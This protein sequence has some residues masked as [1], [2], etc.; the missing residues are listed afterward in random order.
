M[1]KIRFKLLCILLA[2]G[3]TQPIFAQKSAAW[4]YKGEQEGIKIYHQKTPGLLHIKLSTSVKAP[5]SGIAALFS[6]VDNY[7]D[8]GY[9]V[10]HSRLLKRV[11]STELWYYA[12]FDFPWPLDDRDIILHSKMEQDPNTLQIRITN[13]PYPTYLPENKGVMRMKN[14][15]T[16]WLFVPGE[17][18]WVYVEQQISTDSANDMPEWLVKMTAD[19]G[20]RETAKAVRK[21]LR[22]DQYQNARLTH[23]K[24]NK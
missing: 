8:W 20:P 23:I 18:G 22:Q 24:D 5:L 7:K 3:L 9:K 11:S 16:R 13:T 15:T 12:K 4:E 6:D 21:I 14:T 17:D 10:S 2:H 19:T 1:Q